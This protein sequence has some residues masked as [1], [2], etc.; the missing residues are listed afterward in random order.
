MAIDFQDDDADDAGVGPTMN[1]TPLIDVLL[2]LLVML[3]ISIPIRLHAV[4]MDLPGGAPPPDAPLPVVVRLEVS[5]EH[6]LRWNG[7]VIP[8]R[9]ALQGRLAV[10]AQAPEQPEIHIH[11]DPKAKYDAVASVLTDAQAAGLQKIGVVGLEAY[12]QSQP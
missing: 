6:A 7:E 8:G 2:V 4:S 12:A 11:A 5:A 10:A 1:T 9:A 3:I